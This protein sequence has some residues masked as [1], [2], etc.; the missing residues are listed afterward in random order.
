LLASQSTELEALLRTIAN[1]DRQ[2]FRVLYE[3]FAPK[4][5]GIILRI[6]RDPGLSQDV[7]QETFVKV[8]TRAGTYSAEAGRPATWL[9]SIARNAAI[10]AGRRRRDVP[11][12]MDE[13]G[14]AMIDALEPSTVDADP[15]EFEALRNCLQLLEATQRDCVMLAYC[16][17]Y[18]REELATR[19]GRPVG[20]IKTWLH[21]GLAALKT[22]LE[23]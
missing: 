5:Y 21:R 4:L 11:L 18:S 17:G 10:D 15:F 1:G 14:R 7:L 19:F 2:A 13:E 16:E 23:Q 20:T 22:C 12:G 6:C 8:W 3:A 9:A